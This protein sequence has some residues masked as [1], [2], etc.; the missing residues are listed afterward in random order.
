MLEVTDVAFPWVP[1][2]S[3]LNSRSVTQWCDEVRVFMASWPC[4]VPENYE[5]CIVLLNDIS[6]QVWNACENLGNGDDFHYVDVVF[7]RFH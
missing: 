5:W 4:L 7:I 2:V 6:L 1:V 3:M